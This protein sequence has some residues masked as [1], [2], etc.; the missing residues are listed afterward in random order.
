MQNYIN[1]MAVWLLLLTIILVSFITYENDRWRTT[2]PP[3]LW[4]R[5]ACLEYN[6][7]YSLKPTDRPVMGVCEVNGQVYFSWDLDSHAVTIYPVKEKR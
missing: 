7:E 6:G 3:S 1:I 2:I 5:L 4:S